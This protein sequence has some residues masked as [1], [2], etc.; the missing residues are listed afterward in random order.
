M[1]QSGEKNTRL[2]VHSTLRIPKIYFTRL[3]DW[4]SPLIDPH[5][6]RFSSS[7]IDLES[8]KNLDLE[9]I[10]HQEGEIFAMNSFDG[11]PIRIMTLLSSKY[12]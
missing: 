5:K 1:I 9:N 8:N 7:A 10:V 12:S 11:I 4:P 6:K 3:P 2:V